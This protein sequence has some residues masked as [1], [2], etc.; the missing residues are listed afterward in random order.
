MLVGGLGS[1]GEANAEL[2][3]QASLAEPVDYARIS[4]SPSVRPVHARRWMSSTVSREDSAS[5]S[6]EDTPRESHRGGHA[7]G[8]KAL[9]GARDA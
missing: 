1:A 8:L 2:S 9:R 7:G 6:S 4:C 5:A 3:V